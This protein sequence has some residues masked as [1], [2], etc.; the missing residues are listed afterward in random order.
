[1]H[2]VKSKLRE[3]RRS[4]GLTQEELARTVGVSRQAY[5]AV[6]GGKSVP[7]TEV[8]LRLAR[9][10]GRPVEALF[11]LEEDSPLIVCAEALPAGKMSPGARVRMAQVGGRVLARPFAGEAAVI[12]SFVAPSGVV[13]GS[14]SAS[15][16][17]DVRLEEPQVKSPYVVVAGCDPS[18]AIAGDPLRERGVRLDWMETGSS[19]SLGMLAAGEV[20][21]AGCHL[22][23]ETGR[24]VS[25]VVRKIVPFPCT[26][27]GYAAWRQGF[28]VGPSNPLGIS[29]IEDL[30]RPGVRFVNRQPGSGTRA[31]FDRL[32]TKAGMAS[33]AVDGADRWLNGHLAVAEAVQAGLADCAIGI[34]AAAAA[35]GLG[36]VPI[37][38]ERY[39]LVAPNRFAESA[40]VM[41]LL[42]AIRAPSFRRKVESLGGYDGAMMGQTV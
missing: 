19:A 41:A 24:D 8:S 14:S 2:R 3:A 35:Y 29:R 10:L 28:I 33:E 30:G 18:L 23:G 21:I 20:H 38:E 26:I 37:T 13:V 9:A 32:V 25:I 36:F 6:E 1:M 5:L 12:R 34:E 39:D 4:A 17:V 31:L 16:T 7:S 11:E 22:G 42:Q 40:P 27:V 15:G